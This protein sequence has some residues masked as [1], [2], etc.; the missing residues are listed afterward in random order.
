MG[1]EEEEEEKIHWSV[2]RWERDICLWNK[3]G[4]KEKE[5]GWKSLTLAFFLFWREI[6]LDYQISHKR[7]VV[8]HGIWE[9]QWHLPHCSSHSFLHA[10][11][12]WG[13][14][15][16]D[17][18]SDLFLS[19]GC[20]EGR[21]LARGRSLKRWE[22]V[23]GREG[24]PAFA[25][26]MTSYIKHGSRVFHLP[27]HARGIFLFSWSRIGLDQRVKDTWCVRGGC[28]NWRIIF[29]EHGTL[30]SFIT[31]SRTPGSPMEL[32]VNPSSASL[33]P[34]SPR[35]PDPGL[36]LTSPHLRSAKDI[37]AKFCVIG[38]GGG[39]KRRGDSCQCQSHPM[40]NKRPGATIRSGGVGVGGHRRVMDK[41]W[42]HSDICPF[43]LNMA[44]NKPVG[45]IQCENL[46]S[47]SLRR[48]SY[49]RSGLPR[50]RQHRPLWQFN[51]KRLSISVFL[52]K[53]SD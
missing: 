6:T 43:A 14:L 22:L 26:H 20:L 17:L 36:R 37:K 31:K 1:K 35:L 11:L 27:D 53:W 52:H 40:D 33:F 21:R 28:A 2:G 23:P 32:G 39:K 47:A 46:I 18:K 10:F 9:E 49:R 42:G 38:E 44:Q 12:F 13:V 45:F 25:G 24:F 3:R 15:M 29:R 34:S 41:L 4:K 19:P 50:A 5:T 7:R 16:N 30:T 8:N 48:Q 51:S